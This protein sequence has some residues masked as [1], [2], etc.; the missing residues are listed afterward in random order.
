MTPKQEFLAGHNKL[1]PLNLQAPMALLSH[2]KTEKNTLFKGADWSLDKL[3]R[4]FIIWMTSLTAQEK[5][6]INSEET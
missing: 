4:P 2:F 5:E 1:S 3:R 6:S